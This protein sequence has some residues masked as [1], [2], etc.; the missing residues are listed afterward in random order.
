MTERFEHDPTLSQWYKNL[1]HPQPSQKVDESILALA[2]QHAKQAPQIATNKASLFDRIKQG[3]STY[4]VVSSWRKWQWPMGLVAS[5]GCLFL[6]FFDH[7]QSFDSGLQAPPM[8]SQ[9][10]SDIIQLDTP[11]EASPQIE[12]FKSQP[13]EEVVAESEPVLA[14]KPASTDY[15]ALAEQE[16]KLFSEELQRSVEMTLQQEIDQQ[17]SQDLDDSREIS[18]VDSLVAL[19]NDQRQQEMQELVVTGA[20]LAEHSA[21]ARMKQRKASEAKSSEGSQAFLQQMLERHQSLLKNQTTGQNQAQWQQQ[22]A[23]SQNDIF[24]YLQQLK[25][26]NPEAKIESVYLDVL[27]EEQK[28]QLTGNIPESDKP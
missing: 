14:F 19:S 3:V 18:E 8:V 15:E 11:I 24:Q 17:T 23:E 10:Q 28:Q 13:S 7:F 22:I 25:L 21:A 1:R 9:P 12:A 20:R 6:V 26:L 5:A 27:T 2:R 16:A 4:L